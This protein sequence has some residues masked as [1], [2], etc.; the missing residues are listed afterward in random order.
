VVEQFVDVDTEFPGE[1]LARCHQIEKVHTNQGEMWVSVQEREAKAA[2]T[3][4]PVKGKKVAKPSK[5]RRRMGF[6]KGNG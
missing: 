3:L 4:K 5:V 6:N 1:W 2:S